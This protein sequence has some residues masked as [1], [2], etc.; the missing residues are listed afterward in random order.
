VLAALQSFFKLEWEEEEGKVT[1]EEVAG[2][3]AANVWEALRDTILSIA[4]TITT[5]SSGVV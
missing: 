1:G 4:C 3:R 2:L 5:G